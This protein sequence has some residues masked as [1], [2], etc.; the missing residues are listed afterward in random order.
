MSFS[1][2][3]FLL[4][5]LTLPY[6]VGLAW[7]TAKRSWR[8]R[9]GLVLRLLL[10][11]SLV[12]GLAGAQMVRQSDDLAVLFLLDLSDSISAEQRT[13]AES[14]IANA[15][16]TMRPNDHAGLIVF[17]SNALVDRP[18]SP[19]STLESITSL[20]ETIQTNLP[21]AIQLGIALFPP[22]MGRRMVILSDGAN[23]IGNLDEAV[24]L[25]QASGVQVDYVPLLR[26][27]LNNEA[28]LLS[29]TA[30]TQVNEG[31]MLTL[32]ISA[33]STI[34][35]TAKVRVINRNV[36][37][38][39]E[40]VR[41]NAGINHFSLR[42]QATVA[43]FAA[44]TVELQ[45]SADSYPQ[46]NRLGAFTEVV[47]AP[48]VLLVSP[49]AGENGRGQ[50]IVDESAELRNALTAVKIPLETI[51]PQKLP[52]NLEQLADYSAILFVNVNAA[53]ISMRQM[54]SLQQYVRDLGGG[55]VTVGSPQSYGLGGWFETPLE[56]ILPVSMQIKD[57]SR[58]PP[59]SIV[60]VIDRSGS[61]GA[62]ENGVVKIQLA[63]EG[64]ARV[65]QL[66][67]PPDEI[68]VI[69]VD[70]R[71]DEI[72]G[73]YRLS[74]AEEVI[75]RLQQLGAGGGGIYVRAGLE[76][77]A[78]VLRQ[79]TNVVQHIIVLADG[80]DSEQKEG[81]PEL[82]DT[83][84]A[85]GVSVTMVAIGDGPDVPWLREMAE[86]GN[87]QFHLTDRASNL[88]EIFTQEMT[89]IQRNYLIEER[90]FP[91]LRTQSPILRGINAVPPLFG[92][93]GTSLKESAQM[94]LA[95]PKEDPLLAQW[96]YG[97]GR[98]VAWS[99]DATGRW[100]REWVSWEQFPTFWAQA[101]RWTMNTR[102]NT[103]AQTE[104]VYA[105]E[106]AELVVESRNVDGSFL[107]SL[108]LQANIIAPDNRVEMIELS[109][110]AP[111][112]YTG[113]FTPSAEGV[114]YIR[115]NGETDEQTIGQTTGWV[116]GY[117]PEYRQ[118]SGDPDQLARIAAATQGRDLSTTPSA[119]FDQTLPSSRTKQEIWHNLIFLSL[120]L[121]PLEVAF[122]RLSLSR[123]DFRHAQ[124]W[125][126]QRLP[127]Q[128]AESNTRATPKPVIKAPP[129]FPKGE[130]TPPALEE[131]NSA[132]PNTP[133]SSPDSLAS[134]LR[135]KR[136]SKRE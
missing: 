71:P 89:T 107:N 24:R 132:E 116:L 27:T 73:P 104:V 21:A 78:D 123:S 2:P 105:G 51:S 59:V 34:N 131:K 125:I 14:Y 49:P 61:M 93:V 100:A 44:F 92:Y 31:G 16:Q 87:G 85:K 10:I 115:V 66:L 55:F 94:V 75:G 113:S 77:A 96:Q 95:T 121:L 101:V 88:P 106:S 126:A 118:L 90:F 119:V 11:T 79:S 12:L 97:L 50:A 17:G 46:N 41:L 32:R 35:Q 91:T 53:D 63:A 64:A 80:S 112:R 37:I 68:T 4:F 9:V 28:T 84:T 60:I 74:D 114:Y 30:P 76:A 57:S 22:E 43:E 18:I 122:R 58:F 83:L 48:K 127:E 134:R 130:T 26:P 99:S 40:E 110:T 33:E 1:R 102:R 128:S 42:L 72:I 39:E 98:S 5:L 29:V 19:S 36:L 108:S 47:G 82:I 62:E 15:M 65:V 111:G 13:Q 133:P 86:R 117:S 45:P 38:A 70:E 23:T 6:F 67:N 103:A 8:K 120:L 56:A 69:P 3:I 54:E 7:P 136:E 52:F 124:T 109:Q 129:H 81:V 25:A 20:P 135:K